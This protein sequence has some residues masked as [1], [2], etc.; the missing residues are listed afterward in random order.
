MNTDKLTK[1]S[2]KEIILKCASSN[3]NE[4]SKL[5]KKLLAE[6]KGCAQVVIDTNFHETAIELFDYYQNRLKDIFGL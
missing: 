3:I 6:R 1:I 2:Q 5:I 4:D